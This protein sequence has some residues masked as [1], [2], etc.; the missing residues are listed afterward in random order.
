ML[1][2]VFVILL[3]VLL[4]GACSGKPTVE[5]SYK[6]IEDRTTK[7]QVVDIMGNEYTEVEC[8]DG[9]VSYTYFTDDGFI[10]HIVFDGEVV[11]YVTI[12]EI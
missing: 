12:T 6:I 2:K 8:V 4:L 5:N 9:N 1:K 7:E 3:A 11:G 10:I